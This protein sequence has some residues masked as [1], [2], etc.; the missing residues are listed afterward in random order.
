LLRSAWRESAL[1]AVG[2][3]DPRG[4]PELREALADHLRRARGAVADP[5]HALICT[6][7]RQGLSVT[8]RWLRANGI[9]HVALEDPGWHA[10]RLSVEEAGLGVTP[11]PVDAEGS[12]WWS[13]LE[14]AR[15]PSS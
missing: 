6:G 8:C 5:E 14:P 1:D 9:E 15:R 3:G 11:V 2:Y 10:H 4:V 12:T 13:W 7:F